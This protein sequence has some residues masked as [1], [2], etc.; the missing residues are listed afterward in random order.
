M[1]LL[2]TIW[3][4]SKVR[5]VRASKGLRGSKGSRVA[6]ISYL[7]FTTVS[8]LPVSPFI[9]LYLLLS[10]FI[11][12]YLPFITVSSLISFLLPVKLNTT[13]SV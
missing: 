5:R 10:P 8:Y 6:T 2:L 4:G 3:R 11:F 13:P 1:F 7:L 12:F 9:S